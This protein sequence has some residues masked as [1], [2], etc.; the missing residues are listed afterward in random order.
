MGY[1]LR[2]VKSALREWKKL[3]PFIKDQFR[4]HLKERLEH[5]RVESAKL[6]GHRDLYRIELKSVGY[7]LAYGVKEPEIAVYVISVPWRADQ[8][9]PLWEARNHSLRRALPGVVEMAR[10]I[11]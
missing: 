3:D 7:R 10:Q 5:P 9:R 4:E 8:G 2:F 1:R 11:T 6:R